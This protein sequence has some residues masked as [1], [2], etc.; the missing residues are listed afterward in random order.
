MEEKKK[1]KEA[2]KRKNLRF[3]LLPLAYCAQCKVVTLHAEI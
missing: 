3:A 2:E 1:K